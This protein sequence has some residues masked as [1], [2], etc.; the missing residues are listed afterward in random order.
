MDSLPVGEFKSQFADILSQ[1][2]LGKRYLVTYGK[3]KE[4]VAVVIPY[5]CY[6]SNKKPFKLGLLESKGDVVF[7][8]DFEISDEEL[9]GL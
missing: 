9:L 3:K 5:D 7:H 2:R 1:V 6:I 4:K 8:E